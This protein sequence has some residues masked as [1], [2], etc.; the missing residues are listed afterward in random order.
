MAKITFTMCDPQDKKHSTRFD[1]E[2]VES[3]VDA[4]GKEY[5]APPFDTA[6]FKPSFYIPKPFARNSKRIRVTIEEL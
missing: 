2:Q 4:N 5:A 6:R 1:S 3:V